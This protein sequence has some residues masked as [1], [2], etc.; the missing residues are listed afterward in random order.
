MHELV[1]ILIPV[2]NAEEWL[3]ETLQCALNQ[4]WF[5]NEVIV[6]DD[7]STDGSLQVARQFEA[8]NVK[9]LSQEN[10]GACAARNRALQ[11]AQGDYIQ[12]LDADDLMKQDKIELQVRALKEGGNRCIAAA[13]W[14]RFYDE[15]EDGPHPPVP[16]KWDDTDPLEW[17]LQSQVGRAL[18]PSMGWLTPRD[19]IQ[20]TRPWNE[21]LRINQDGEYFARVLLN[22]TRIIFCPK[23]VVYYRSGIPN[24]VSARRSI[25]RHRSQYKAA[26]S[27]A[28]HMMAHEDSPRV[29]SSCANAFQ[30]VA[31]AAY[32]TAMDVVREA[33]EKADSLGGGS[34]EPPGSRFFQRIGRLIGW[35]PALWL[36]HMYWS[37]RYS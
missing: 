12:Y 14:C 6:V 8:P 19:V 15:I 36:R 5:N 3:A 32:P 2:Y 20:E 7:G 24:S 27:I 22:T 37:L 25:E 10:Q 17:L 26:L 21:D 35:K 34:F 33:E 4:T 31:Y 18:Q 13:R 30:R 9:V 1:S 23:A 11:H 16:E 29:R 28:E